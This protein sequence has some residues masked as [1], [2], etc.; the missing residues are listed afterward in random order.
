MIQHWLREVV[1][2]SPLIAAVFLGWWRHAR[3]RTRQRRNL[4]GQIDG[5]RAAFRKEVRDAERL[6][7][8]VEELTATLTAT[9]RDAAEWKQLARAE[10][11]LAA[12]RRERIEALE[13]QAGVVDEAERVLHGGPG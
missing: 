10:F 7:Q 8:L 9:R 1:P 4:T 2:A 12:M 11:L 13:L 3:W 6:A 5:W